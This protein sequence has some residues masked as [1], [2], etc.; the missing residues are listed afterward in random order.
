MYI[1]KGF[2]SETL[3]DNVELCD[4][5]GLGGISRHT[6]CCCCCSDGGGGINIIWVS[7]E[8]WF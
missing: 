4:T 2:E 1:L 3:N 6:A 7:L 8:E 5:S